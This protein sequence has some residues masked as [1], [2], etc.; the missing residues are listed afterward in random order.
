MKIALLQ[1]G[2]AA[3]DVAANLAQIEEGA[4]QAAVRGARLLLA[5]ELALPGYGAGEAFHDLAEPADGPQVRRLQALSRAHGLAIVAG[6]AERD[7]ARIYNSLVMVDGDAA[8]TVYRKTHLYGDYEKSFFTPAAVCSTLREF[9]GVK[10]GFLICYDVE[11]PENV[12]RLA[13]AG[14]QLVLV[15]TAL[16]RD[17][18]APFI[19]GRMLPVRAFENQIFV[20]YANHVGRDE[21]F[22]YAG[23]SCVAAPD[24][25]TLA[26]AGDDAPALLIADLDPGAYE[27]S[28]SANRYLA[29]L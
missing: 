27:A 16:P 24:G 13:L 4:G 14:A 20:A 11:F 7:G 10:L 21:R 5:P 23:L 18:F 2:A 6:F 1:M 17:S 22:A 9:E 12:R 29:D 3:G 15:P 8:P 26:A 25:E 19:A 28:R